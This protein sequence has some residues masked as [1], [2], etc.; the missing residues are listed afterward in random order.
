ME[1]SVQHVINHIQPGNRRPG[2]KLVPK[3]LTIH[4]TA[5][6]NSNALQE[7]AWLTNKNNTNKYA[8]WHLC[9]DDER[10]VESIPL[11]ETAWH[12]GDGGQGTGNRHSLSLE[13]CESGNKIITLMHAILVVADLV[14]E[15]NIDVKNI[16]PHSKWTKTACP[17]ILGSGKGALWRDFIKEVEQEVERRR[18]SS[19]PVCRIFI[20][21]KYVTDGILV[22]GLS[23]LP[24]R[25]FEGT[26]YQVKKW[27]SGNRSV[28]L[29]ECPS[30]KEV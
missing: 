1:F 5:N 6:P 17:S 11:D 12:A 23:Y 26:C 9:V 16:V 27:E 14:I 3:Y 19:N 22:D 10:V 24:T 2:Y 28:Y 15:Y 4:S 13:I 25:F 18:D 30:T 8:S 7:R 29:I 20:D 21:K